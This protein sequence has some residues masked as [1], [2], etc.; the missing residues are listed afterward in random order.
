[1]IVMFSTSASSDARSNS[2]GVPRTLFNSTMRSCL[3]TARS[4]FARFQSCTGPSPTWVIIN[5]LPFGAYRKSMPKDGASARLTETK[6]SLG[7]CTTRFQ[8]VSALSF[9]IIALVSIVTRLTSMMRSCT[10]K[11]STPLR[12]FHL[13]T[14]PAFTPTTTADTLSMR[15]MSRPIG[16]SAPRVTVTLNVVPGSPRLS[17]PSRFRC[18]W[19]AAGSR[20]AAGTS[21][22]APGSRLGM[23]LTMELS[24]IASPPSALA[25]QHAASIA[26]QRERPLGSLAAQ[27]ANNGA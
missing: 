1:M 2:S 3:Q 8:V 16:S 7:L 15:S 12:S 14:A 6:N 26:K 13:R 19:A 5:V 9:A 4:G 25:Q 22:I 17:P 11:A 20:A 27:A 23:L 10:C 24:S 18:R 21:S